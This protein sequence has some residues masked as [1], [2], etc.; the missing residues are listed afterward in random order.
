MKIRTVTVSYG[1]G[2]S[3]VAW[4]FDMVVPEYATRDF[5]P[6]KM[7]GGLLARPHPEDRQDESDP[8]SPQAVMREYVRQLAPLFQQMQQAHIITVPPGTYWHDGCVEFLTPAGDVVMIP[9]GAV[10]RLILGPIREPGP[11]DAL[12]HPYVEQSKDPTRLYCAACG[13]SRAEHRT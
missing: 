10:A 5:D 3:G 7:L 13:H 8:G 11:T 12:G 4:A 1:P 9:L 6:D 2:R